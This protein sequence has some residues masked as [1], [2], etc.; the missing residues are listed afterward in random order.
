MPGN[1]PR[2][3]GIKCSRRAAY[4]GGY[5][6]LPPNK[7]ALATCKDPRLSSVQ[8]QVLPWAPGRN[9][10]RLRQQSAGVEEAQTKQELPKPRQYP[11]A[12]GAERTN[13][14]VTATADGRSCSMAAFPSA[15][16][17]CGRRD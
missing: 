6:Q 14:N 2:T 7:F 1:A 10:Q 12:F 5:R 9:A 3:S 17:E 11:Q 13:T 4:L 15:R 8:S 16:P